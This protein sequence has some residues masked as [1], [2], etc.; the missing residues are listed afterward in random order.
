MTV[1]D[2]HRRKKRRT[3]KPPSQVDRTR[4]PQWRSPFVALKKSLRLKP[5]TGY[6]VETITED[7]KYGGDP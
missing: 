4:D 6:R 7:D 1:R 3:A 2:A 5:S